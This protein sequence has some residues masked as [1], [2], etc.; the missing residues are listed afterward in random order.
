MS[1]EGYPT[2]YRCDLCDF[3]TRKA[4]TFKKHVTSQEHLSLEVK[5]TKGSMAYFIY[6]G[7]GKDHIKVK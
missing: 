3:Q 2:C 7:R 1:E 5:E 4:E 6:F